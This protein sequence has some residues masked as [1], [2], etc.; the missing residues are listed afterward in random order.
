MQFIDAIEKAI[1]GVMRDAPHL[2]DGFR[3]GIAKN[4]WWIVGITAVLLTLYALY[5]IFASM[6]WG[7][8]SAVTLNL[9]GFNWVIAIFCAF[10]AMVAVAAVGPLQKMQARGW[11]GVF[12]LWLFFTI[13]EVIS[14]FAN[15]SMGNLLWTALVIIF[16]AY[17][18]YEPREYFHAKKPAKKLVDAEIIAKNKSPKK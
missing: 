9:A 8:A 1:G 17:A 10:M 7:L 18:I 15:F 12:T 3:K 2:S 6:F 16:F 5:L 11:R 4:L 13:L 14:L